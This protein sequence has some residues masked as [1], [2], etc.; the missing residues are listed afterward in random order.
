ME[1]V[2]DGWECAL[3]GFS[4]QDLF[5]Y[6]LLACLKTSSSSPIHFF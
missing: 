2:V 6:M 5:V 4:Q 1:I 3:P